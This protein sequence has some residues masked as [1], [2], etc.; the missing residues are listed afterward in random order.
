MP[1]SSGNLPIEL[2]MNGK[3]FNKNTDG[4]YNYKWIEE[5]CQKRNS[6]IKDVYYAVIN[7]NGTLF[8]DLYDDHLHSPT[9]ME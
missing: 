6:D 5:Q 4:P 7:S 3:I 8:I 9:D 2:I 1:P